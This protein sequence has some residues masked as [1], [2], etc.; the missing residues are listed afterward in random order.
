M[1]SSNTFSFWF[2][3]ESV[4]KRHDFDT[5]ILSLFYTMILTHPFWVHVVPW[6]RHT[7]I[8]KDNFDEFQLVKQRH[9][10]DTLLISQKNTRFLNILFEDIHSCSTAW[11]VTLSPN[12]TWYSCTR[13]EYMLNHIQYIYN[14]FSA[15][16][17]FII[18]L[19]LIYN[20]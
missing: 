16:H 17:S 13:F 18:L 19:R 3:T 6:F 4:R 20:L 9:D 5:P 2:I 14:Y 8:Q 12:G 15:L 10:F 1:F 7:F 11:S